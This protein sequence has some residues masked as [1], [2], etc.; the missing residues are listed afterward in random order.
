VSHIQ[1]ATHKSTIKLCIT[2]G[3]N[4]ATA[5]PGL[6][7]KLPVTHPAL[8]RYP[9]AMLMWC[10]AHNVHSNRSNNQGQTT[11]C[12]CLRQPHGATG[13]DILI[14]ILVACQK[15]HTGAQ[16]CTKSTNVDLQLP[17]EATATVH[18]CHN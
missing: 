11:G 5:D 1:H 9:G 3:P 12:I 4:T 13:Y 6:I 18:V 7:W 8:S 16:G 10:L 17:L 15:Q 14:D 2:W